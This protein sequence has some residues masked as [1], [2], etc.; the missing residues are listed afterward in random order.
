M[1]DWDMS[2]ETMA[3]LL[4]ERITVT[5]NVAELVPGTYV[6]LDAEDEVLATGAMDDDQARGIPPA[7]AEFHEDDDGKT[8][9]GGNTI[10]GPLPVPRLPAP[11]Q[12]KKK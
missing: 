1:D 2:D 10:V 5:F 9:P 4:G 6:Y 8:D 3:A 7:L 11:R 12:T